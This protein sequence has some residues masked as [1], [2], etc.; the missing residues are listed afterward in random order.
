[1]AAR[2]TYSDEDLSRA[3]SGSTSWRGVLRE[4]G[5]QSTSS[6]MIRSV[7][8]HADRLELDHRHFRGQRR[9]TDDE[10]RAAV[11]CESRWADV[12]EAMG[13]QGGSAVS[14]LKGHAAR[15]GLDTSHFIGQDDRVNRIA[16]HEPD[17]A[18]LSRAGSML[19][20]AWFA[21]SG[22]DVAWPLEPARYDL[23]VT[24]ETCTRRVQV[25]TTVTKDG[26]S[27]QVSLS[28]TSGGRRTYDPDEIDDFF[29]ID[30]A[31]GHY[32]IPIEAVGGLH[33]INLRAYER[34]RLGNLN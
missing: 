7:R 27:W 23:L 19:A 1:M 30:G 18:N 20:A 10:L 5:L 26:S 15:L 22:Y 32:L 2:R 33:T 6:T 29:V 12:V 13:I 16:R 3:V 11:L 28:T 24:Q 21:L 34:Y 4:L 17:I 31:L 9:W 25:K 8:A 14:T